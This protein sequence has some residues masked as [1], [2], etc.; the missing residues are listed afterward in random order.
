[1]LPTPGRSP[2]PI[3]YPYLLKVE[4]ASYIPGPGFSSVFSTNFPLEL[5][6][7]VAFLLL[8]LTT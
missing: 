1:M 8:D 4:V 3:E 7:I 6:P 2:F 5:V